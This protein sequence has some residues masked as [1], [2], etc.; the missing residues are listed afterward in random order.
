MSNSTQKVISDTFFLANLVAKYW[1]MALR[2][3]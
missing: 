3:R 1:S 2:S